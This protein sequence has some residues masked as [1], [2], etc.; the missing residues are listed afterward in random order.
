M[1]VDK[2]WFVNNNSAKRCTFGGT[3]VP[4]IY[5]PARW[6]YHWVVRF[7]LMRPLSVEHYY[8]PLFADSA[9]VL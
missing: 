8:F 6:S 9:Q 4:Y 2:S 1:A 7:L 5:S 3:Y